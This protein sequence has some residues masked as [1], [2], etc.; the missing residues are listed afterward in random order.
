MRFPVGLSFIWRSPDA[1]ELDEIDDTLAG[2][3][4]SPG[5]RG[6]LALTRLLAS[7][8]KAAD[9]WRFQ[10]LDCRRRYDELAA[11]YRAATEELSG[12]RHFAASTP[13]VRPEDEPTPMEEAV[14]RDLG[15]DLGITRKP[16]VYQDPEDT[17]HH[18]LPVEGEVGPGTDVT[19]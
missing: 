12:L 4:L 5:H 3:D 11:L 2:F 10:T 17:A 14:R 1:A 18:R 7:A 6:V 16:P 15:T 9:D 19:G 8:E 13:V